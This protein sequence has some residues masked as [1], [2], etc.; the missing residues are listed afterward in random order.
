MI[1]R[2][3]L[4]QALETVARSASRD[5]DAIAKTLRAALPDLIVSTCD[6]DDVCGIPPLARTPGVNLYL[7]SSSGACLGL[8]RDPEMALGLVLAQVTD[9]EE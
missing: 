8:T 3:T 7:L 1:D 9:P 2:E 5:A 6:D 4:A